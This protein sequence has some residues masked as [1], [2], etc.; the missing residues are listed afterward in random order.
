MKEER[1]AKGVNKFKERT[2][3]GVKISKKGQLRGKM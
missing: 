1:T 3:Q 2:T